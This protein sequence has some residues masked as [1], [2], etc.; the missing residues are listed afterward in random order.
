MEMAQRI[1]GSSAKSSQAIEGGE[2]SHDADIALNGVADKLSKLKSV[3][4]TVNELIV[5]A[6]DSTRLANIYSGSSSPSRVPAD[7]S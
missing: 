5:M 2:R 4:H 6:T 3:E 1:Q 7:S